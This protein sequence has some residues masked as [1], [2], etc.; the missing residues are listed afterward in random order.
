MIPRQP[1]KELSVL[2]GNINVANGRQPAKP[3]VEALEARYPGTSNG[4]SVIITEANSYREVSLP[5]SEKLLIDYK[6]FTWGIYRIPQP[7][8][9]RG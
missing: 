5:S 9:R 6:G 2:S 1:G 3:L 8:P 4:W 7:I